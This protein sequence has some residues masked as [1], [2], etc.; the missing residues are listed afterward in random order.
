MSPLFSII[1]PCYNQAHFLADCLDSLFQQS[2]KHW[3]AIVVNDGATDNTSEVANQFSQN[4]SRIKL[5]EKVNGGLSSARNRGIQEGKGNYFIF[6][7]ADD[8]FINDCLSIYERIVNE[9]NEFIQSGYLCFNKNRN[10]ILYKRRTI[11][12][13]ENFLKSIL[14]SNVGPVNGFVLSKK[15]V[16]EVGFFNE[17]LTSCEDWDYWIRCAKLGYSPYVINDLLVAFRFVPKSM[18]KNSI[19]MLEQGFLV[20]NNHHLQVH[21]KY[22][23]K[24]LIKDNHEYKNACL[25]YLMFATGIALFDFNNVIT[26]IIKKDYFEN[27]NEKLEIENCAKI[28]NYQT[29]RVF[30]I[31]KYFIF[32]FKNKKQYFNFFNYLLDKNIIDINT[33]N[34]FCNIIFPNPITMNFNKFI[35]RIRLIK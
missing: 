9:G 27:L 22:I 35:K 1:I 3:E 23:Q 19:R 2:Y 28:S 10:D 20:I 29:Y 12:N 15:I 5:V 30:S 13:Y 6:L 21:S 4:D 17:Q 8:L 31:F 26:D 14:H 25:S 32:Y 33:Y 16:D 7:D 11:P 34:G 18:S 24:D